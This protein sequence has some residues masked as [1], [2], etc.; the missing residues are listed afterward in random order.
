MKGTLLTEWS[1]E[2]SHEKKLYLVHCGFYESDLCDGIYESH[3][4]F[5]IAASSF[6]EARSM[7]KSLPAFK[8]RRMHIDGLQEIALVDGFRINLHEEESLKGQ[9]VINSQRHRDFAP[10]PKVEAKV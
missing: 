3:V 1:S 4:N 10:P 2:I 8:N 7:A 6:E 5:F 9:T